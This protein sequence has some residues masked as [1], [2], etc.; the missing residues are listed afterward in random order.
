MIAPLR[1]VATNPVLVPEDVP[2]ARCSG[3][4]N[5][6]AVVD[7]RTGRV[8]LLF[9]AY[10]SDSGRSSIG[11]ATSADGVTMINRATVTKAGVVITEIT[12][13]FRKSR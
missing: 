2:F 1:R 5:A 4:F 9:R 11:L 6:G 13:H 3:V 7:E 8:V 12:E 10:E